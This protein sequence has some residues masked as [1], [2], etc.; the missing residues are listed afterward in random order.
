MGEEM[1]QVVCQRCR[2]MQ[3]VARLVRK[4]NRLRVQEQPFEPE[5]GSLSVRVLVAISIVDH[6]RMTHGLRVYPY[7]V[8]A[9]GQRLAL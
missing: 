9:A 7:L 2:E 8:S 1:I 5:F 4:R 3:L 6:Y